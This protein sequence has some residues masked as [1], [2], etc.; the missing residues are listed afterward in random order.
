MVAA[1]LGFHFTPDQLNGWVD[2]IEHL[3]ATILPIV[4]ALIAVFNF[5]N[6][7]GKITS[8]TAT[9]NANIQAA[10][11]MGPATGKLGAIAGV[12]G[13]VGSL[14]GLHNDG[15]TGSLQSSIFG[16]ENWKD[17]QRYENI[18]ADVVPLLGGLF[19]KKATSS[20]KLNATE[21]AQLEALLNKANG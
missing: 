20:P 13:T 18:I 2:L 15:N 7:R 12:A 4:T 16:G 3:A 17:P 8:N 11:L 5:T 21:Q 9:A 6:S 19:H 1:L 14:A 10:A